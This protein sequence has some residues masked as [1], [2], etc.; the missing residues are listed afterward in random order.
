MSVVSRKGKILA[1]LAAAS[2][3]AWTASA[4]AAWL[5]ATTKHFVIY[6]DMSEAKLR[7][8]AD[9]MERFDGAMRQIVKTDETKPV[10]VY[11]VEDMGEVQK[12]AGRRNV[13]GFY[14]PSAQGNYMV[15]PLK[16]Q[17]N[18][19]V[20]NVARHVYFHEYAHHMTLSTSGS[21]YPGW[22]TEGMAEFFGTADINEDGSVTLGAAPSMRTYTIGNANR[23]TV[24]QLLTSDTRKLK[25][26]ETEQRYSRGWLMVHYLMLGGKRNGQLAQ[27]V[28]LINKTVPPLEAGKKVFGDLKGLNKEIDRYVRSATLPGLTFTP[29]ALKAGIDIKVRPVSP[30]MDRMMPTR[31]RSAIGVTKETA[32]KVAEAGRHAATGFENDVWVQRSLAEMEYDANNLDAA[33]AAAD[34]A[35]AVEPA[36]I[37]AML[38]KGRAYARRALESK[39]AAD[40]KTAQSWFL[41]ANKADPDHA[42][43]FLLY[44]DTFT[45]RG[46]TPSDGALTGLLRAIVLV[47]QDQQ[48][49]FRIGYAYVLRGDLKAARATFAPVAFNAE[50]GDDNKA[51]K[52]VDAID[53]G[54]DAAAVQAL[55]KELELD[56]INDF[57]PP[58]DKKDKDKDKAKEGK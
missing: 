10:T 15:I 42:M 41:K 1:G 38:Y 54:K 39:S 34:R 50:N 6:G 58:E 8:F 53:A 27:Y 29:D 56:K 45:A 19:V 3:L 17:G 18:N 26:D 33:E 9:N 35:L 30:G 11:V 40:W 49:N 57:I 55:A 14:Q 48:I 5:E 37:M 2:C 23:W 16:A 52:L 20:R 43:P 22:V 28:S 7:Q 24:E 47:P 46:I 12:L 44:Y 31:I 25:P 4:H 36:N 51:R 21:F 32:P 13:G